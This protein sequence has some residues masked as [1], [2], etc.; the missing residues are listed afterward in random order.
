MTDRCE[1]ILN[2]LS[3][4][5]DLFDSTLGEF[6]IN[7]VYLYLKGGAVPKNHKSFP[8]VRNNE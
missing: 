1:E 5:E 6:H 3:Q 2:L 7:P 4:F 8:L